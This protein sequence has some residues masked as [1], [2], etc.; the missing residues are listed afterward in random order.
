MFDV[1]TVKREE[2]IMQ[3]PVRCTEILHVGPISYHLI[4]EDHVALLLHQYAVLFEHSRVVEPPAVG[5]W[6]L[7]DGLDGDRK[8]GI[9]LLVDTTFTSWQ[10][11]PR[12]CNSWTTLP[13]YLQLTNTNK[14]GFEDKEK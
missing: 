2:G 11:Q 3:R 14:E 13:I 7:G 1:I 10:L 9:Q 4:Q 5:C 6:L 12:H 8:G